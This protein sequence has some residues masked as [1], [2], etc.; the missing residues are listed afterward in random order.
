MVVGVVVVVVS[1]SMVEVSFRYASANLIHI[2]I[3]QSSQ[4]TEHQNS[5]DSAESLST[6][7]QQLKTNIFTKS[8]HAVASDLSELFTFVNNCYAEQSN[9]YFGSHIILSA[10]GVQQGDPLG[11]LLYIVC[12]LCHWSKS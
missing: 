7:R 11:P 1:V 9:L 10:E 5:S 4:R 3:P 12:I 6:F 8:L 2:C